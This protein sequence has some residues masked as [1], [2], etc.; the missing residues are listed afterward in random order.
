MTLKE[1]IKNISPT[2]LNRGK[3]YFNDEH[4][5]SLYKGQDNI[6]Y[7]EI[8][9]SYD[10]YQ[11]ELVLDANGNYSSSFCDCCPYDGITF[12]NSPC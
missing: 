10:N 12:D 5:L 1:F 11:V 4:I 7:A 2:I 3:V 9:G 6:W 8:E